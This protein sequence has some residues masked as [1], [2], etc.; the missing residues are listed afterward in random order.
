MEYLR[1]RGRLLAVLLRLVSTFFWNLCGD[2][3]FYILSIL[4]RSYIIRFYPI[5]QN[6]YVF[7]K[8][9]GIKYTQRLEKIKLPTN[10]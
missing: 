6:I 1:A 9:E 7:N 5:F 4:S 3:G 10:K 2:E 8:K